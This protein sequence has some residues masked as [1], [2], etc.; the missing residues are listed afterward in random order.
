MKILASTIAVLFIAVNSFAQDDSQD[1][2]FNNQVSFTAGYRSIDVTGYE[3]GF[4]QMFGLQSGFRLFD[5]NFSGNAK[6]GQNLFAD[7]YYVT[8]NG[9][10][11]D[12]YLTTHV[13]VQKN[14]IY[15]FQVSFR[16]SRYYWDFNDQ[17]TLPSGLHG[18]TSNH[19][20]STIRQLGSVNFSVQ[21]SRNLKFNFEYSKNTR[22]GIN[23]STRNLDY[24]GSSSVWGSFARA[25]PY[26]VA[27]SIQEEANRVTSSIDY[28]ISSSNPWSFHYRI[29]YQTFGSAPTGANLDS[30]ER[31]INI[32]DKTTAKEPVDSI[33]WSEF[34][35]LKTPVSEFSYTGSASSKL[36]LRG[37]Y[38]FYRYQG[39]DSLDM[40]FNGIARTTSTASTVAPYNISVWMRG[41]ATEPNHV[42]EQGFTYH[43]N[44]WLDAIFDYKYS[45]MSVDSQSEFRSIS[46]KVV[47]KGDVLSQWRIK[48]HT[49]GTNLVFMPVDNLILQ[50]GVRVL[51]N[52]IVMLEDGAVDL[53]RTKKIHTLWPIASLYYRPSKMLTV[54]VD[55]DQSLNTTSYTRLTPHT[56]IGGRFVV[57]FN[58]TSKISIENSGVTRNRTLLEVDYHNTV[59]SNASVVEYALDKRLALMGGFSYEN[60][61]SSNFANF[62]RGTPPITNLLLQ[63]HT[64]SRIWQAGIRAE[65][66]EHF[67]VNLTGNYIRTTGVGEISGE[68]PNYGPLRFPYGTFSIYY[69][70]NKVGRLTAELQQVNYT[71]E[72][73]TGNNFKTRIFSIV[74]TKG[75]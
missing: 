24:F 71:E 66:L 15:D 30:P 52:D 33:S 26:P 58:P 32:D 6:K 68:P 9:F 12:P 4:K 49:L 14:N 69:D 61:M 39:P 37:G 8:M 45:G 40:S 63:D 35:N 11:G 7:R 2:G 28:M 43:V 74:W 5:L 59:R 53:V 19:D 64:I 54:R 25:N 42:V 44:N 17:A 16:K 60:L 1:Q 67:G 75:F 34:R 62:L 20:W 29:G 55:A 36:N 3:P 50:A 27:V 47:T 18:L 51:N 56:D 57:K 48:T 13:G 70:F 65:P 72:I 23:L 41:K 31:S 38:T 21:P 46:G 22:N 10:G 73:V